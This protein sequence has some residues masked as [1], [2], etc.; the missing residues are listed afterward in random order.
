MAWGVLSYPRSVLFFPDILFRYVALVCVSQADL[1]Q[2]PWQR[3]R[4]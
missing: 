4:L 2:V 3:R 1:D